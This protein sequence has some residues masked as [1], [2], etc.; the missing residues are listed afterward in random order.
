MPMSRRRLFA[1][2]GALLALFAAGRHFANVPVDPKATETVSVEIPPGL[3]ARAIAGR[4]K[5]AGVLR[6][7]TGFVAQVLLRGARGQL[8]AG[9]YQVSP[10]ESGDAILRRLVRGDTL[11][12]DLAIT[13]P[14]GFTLAQVA[15]RVAA[16]GR[17]SAEQF[18]AAAQVDRFQGEFAVLQSVPAGATLE[19]YLFPDTYRVRPGESPDDLIRRMLRRF[20]EQWSTAR[21]TCVERNRREA[22]GISAPPSAYCFLPATSR[23]HA[24]VSMASIIEREVRSTEDR[25]LVSGI[26][27]KRFEAGVGLDADATIRYALGNWEKPLTVDDLR[28]NSPYN[29][30]RYR[31]LPPGPIGNPGLDS[32]VAALDPTS[33]EHLYYLSA[34]EDGR[35]IFS[36]TLEEHNAAKAQHLR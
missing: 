16:R 33:S 24:L 5:D 34:S 36:R 6:S 18:L 35:T 4:L 7:P 30:R 12:S 3:S 2:V 22:T 13:F 25:R 31:G 17:V 21:K 9:T 8:K 20:E 14:E 19:G 1:L 11:P 23:V 27:W 15:A 28:V 29:T 32:L 10:R 26:L